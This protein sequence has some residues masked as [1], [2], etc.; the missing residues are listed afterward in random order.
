MPPLLSVMAVFGGLS[1]LAVGGGAAVLPQ[2]QKEVLA[3]GWVTQAQFSQLYSLG[4][5]APGPNMTM[6][7]LLG[8]QAAGVAGG[9][10]ALLAFLTPSSLL[11]FAVCRMWRR[12]AD[13]PWRR[14]LQEGLA[15]I[16]I[17]L[18]FSGVWAISSAAVRTPFQAALAL[19][20]ALLVARTR[21]NPALLILGA[22]LLGFLLDC[23]PL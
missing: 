11:T 21:L 13:S 9:P 5:L 19:S 2:M 17:G 16:T 7:I 12:A 8:Y 4:Q 22:G 18:M 6:V 10:L 14:A 1:L 3:Q 20:V 15:P 23:L